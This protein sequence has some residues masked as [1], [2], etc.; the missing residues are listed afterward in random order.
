M[1]GPLKLNYNFSYRIA[2]GSNTYFKINTK[3][4]AMQCH[5]L[6]L[7]TPY[8]ESFTTWQRSVVVEPLWAA[9]WVL[10]AVRNTDSADTE[11]PAL[12]N[13]KL[14]YRNLH[15]TSPQSYLWWLWPLPSGFLWCLLLR[16][17][18]VIKIIE[19]KILN[20]C[21]KCVLLT[22]GCIIKDRFTWSI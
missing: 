12:L 13:R 3:H 16:L 2:G 4:T 22:I 21:R 9:T 10:F 6:Q 17:P 11:P 7:T 14:L 5:V 18:S 1:Y 15:F 8:C 20:L 19:N